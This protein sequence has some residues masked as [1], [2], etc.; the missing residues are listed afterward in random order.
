M[1][2][3]TCCAEKRLA[4]FGLGRSGVAAVDALIAGGATVI[5]WDD[6]DAARQALDGT[7]AEVTDL[8][9]VDF[10]TLDALVLAPGVP[11][12]HPEPHWTVVKA[13][14][15]GLEVIGDTE[16]FVRELAARSTGAKL[17]AITGTN[18]KS[19]T[20]ALIGHVLASAGMDVQIGGNIGTAILSLAPPA[21]GTVYVVEFS[22]YQIDLTPG[23]KP[24][25]AILLNITP[26]HLDRH[27]TLEHYASVKA[28]IFSQQEAGDTAV[29]AVDDDICRGIAD[30]LQTSARLVRVSAESALA[31][32]IFSQGTKLLWA[33]ETGV[34][35]CADLD[36]IV[37]LRGSH[38]A[39][40]AAAAAATAQA[41][42][43]SADE[44]KH[45]FSTF[46]GLS[47]RMEQV[48]VLDGV[49]FI[50]DSKATNADAAAR[51]LASFDNIYWI[52]GGLAKS[53]GIQ[54]LNEFFPKIRRA[55]L[56]GDA[57]EAFAAFMSPGVPC[58]IAGTVERA[59]EA[60]ARDAVADGVRPA[61]VVFSPACASFDQFRNFELRGDAF[62]A[63]VHALEG[64]ERR[65]GT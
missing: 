2:P 32:G 38:N 58:E 26:D 60:A 5:A 57:A 27:G 33:D 30:N 23:L 22:S 17:V 14:E 40:N 34:S 49:L 13:A 39:Q 52:A 8:R 36:G 63:A 61:A 16:L 45:G 46:P 56:I 3:L 19:T 31:N 35:D 1:I 15:A 48:G 41:L 4:V 62:T 25:I 24:D 21:S 64:V 42:G 47:H 20:T 55:Y 54:N 43:L 29:I 53:G 65:K 18:G 37:A 51:A 7:A 11:L 9:E 28:R 12:T 10:A 50:N 59:V 44:T 6:N